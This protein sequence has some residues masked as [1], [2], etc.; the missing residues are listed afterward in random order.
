M[1]AMAGSYADQHP[2]RKRITRTTIRATNTQVRGNKG[3]MKPKQI[4]PDD[5]WDAT[6]VRRRIQSALDG[7]GIKDVRPLEEAAGVGE[8]SLRKFLGG[9]SQNLDLKNVVKLARAANL[10]VSQFL[11][12]VTM[13]AVSPAESP[14]LAELEQRIRFQAQELDRLLGMLSRRK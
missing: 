8:G 3:R 4:I 1:F 10:T 6:V 12:E 14:L 11:G 2:Q 9:A 5:A 13:P 7:I